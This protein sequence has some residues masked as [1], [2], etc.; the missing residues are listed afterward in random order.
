MVPLEQTWIDL[1][2]S[3]T[4]RKQMKQ[5]MDAEVENTPAARFGRSSDGLGS[6]TSIDAAVTTVEPTDA[7]A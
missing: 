3:D 6:G 2:Y 5:M 7:T 4:Q 1:G